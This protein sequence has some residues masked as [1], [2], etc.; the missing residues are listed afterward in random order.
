M[1]KKRT[2][3]ILAAGSGLRMGGNVQKQFL[4]LEG[5]PLI[6]HTLEHFQRADCIDEI[7]LV[8]GKESIEYCRKQIVEKFHFTKVHKITEGGRERYD[9]VYQGLLASSDAGYV[10]IHDGARIFADESLLERGWQQV[11]KLNSAVAAVP[12]KDTMKVVVGGNH[13]VESTPDRST[14]WSA[15]TP[16]IFEYG[17]IRKAYDRLYESDREG[18]T[19]DA[20]VLERFS[21]EP[22]FLFEGSYR[23]IKIT[24]PDDLPVAEAYLKMMKAEKN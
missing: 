18:I 21:D 4:E 10:F 8:T 7:I 13:Q 2:A 6:C 14:V 9:S 16:Q 20:M 11:Q 23:N 24:T 12:A 22:V 3:I 15:Q 1:E 19:D 5:R 17:R